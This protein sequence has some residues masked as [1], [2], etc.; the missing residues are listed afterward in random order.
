MS[1]EPPSSVTASDREVLLRLVDNIDD[2]AMILL[3]PRGIV[4]SWNRGAERLKG[5]AAHEIIGQSFALFY[6]R[7]AVVVGHPKR[8]LEAASAVGHYAEEGWRVRRDGTRFWAHVRI[9]AIFS[10]DGELRGF[11]KVTR[12]LTERKQAEDQQANVLAL[13]E[14]TAR[15][16]AL[17]GLP[18]RRSWDEALERELARA[19]RTGAPLSIAVIDLDGFK[20]LNDRDGHRAGDRF[21]KRCATAWRQTLRT[22]DVLARYGGDEFALCLPDCADDAAA[23]VL[24]RL[25][26]A[27]PDDRRCS[28]GVATWDRS[29]SS[30]TLLGRADTAMYAAKA[31]GRDRA[32]APP[33]EPRADPGSGR[34]FS[35]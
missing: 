20:Q 28:T 24:S 9:V 33:P 8:E 19:E 12:D 1:R 22:I 5:Y 18:N 23:F 3:D 26:A 7:E 27:T 32:T 31:E 17:T 34:L 35:G 16:D 15:T 13:L 21:L 10:D 14:S 30:D 4:R 25:R 2:V 6:P 11:G 29:E